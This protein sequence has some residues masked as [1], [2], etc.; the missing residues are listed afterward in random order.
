MTSNDLSKGKPAQQHLQYPAWFLFLSRLMYFKVYSRPLFF[1]REN[2]PAKET[3]KDAKK[4]ALN[5]P[6][7]TYL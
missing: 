5:C 3:N 6:N 7:A 2:K 1:G 4:K